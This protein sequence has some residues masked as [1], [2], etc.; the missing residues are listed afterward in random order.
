MELVELKQ[1]VESRDT[2]LIDGDT[3]EKKAEKLFETYL[4]E[5]LEKV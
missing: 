3:P 2:V 1:V 4:K 5:R